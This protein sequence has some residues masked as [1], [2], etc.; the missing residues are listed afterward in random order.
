[1]VKDYINKI[2]AYKNV[3]KNKN[4]EITNLKKIDNNE[5]VLLN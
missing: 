5:T 4:G 2:N 3:I 1:M